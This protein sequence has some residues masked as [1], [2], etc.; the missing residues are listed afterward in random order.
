[1]VDLNTMVG[2]TDYLSWWQIFPLAGL[3]GVLVFWKIYRDK[4]M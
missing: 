3:I 2:I 4:Q 1:M